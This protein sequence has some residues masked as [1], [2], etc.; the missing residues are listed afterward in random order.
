LST[1]LTLLV[2]VAVSAIED[3]ETED[4]ETEG[5]GTADEDDADQDEVVTSQRRRNG[6]QSPN[7]ADSSRPARYRAW[8][9]STYTLFPSKSIRLSTGSS[10][11]SRTR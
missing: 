10:P 1:W 6:S 2:V 11:S 8:S 3:V 4:V 7:W 5:E 9:K